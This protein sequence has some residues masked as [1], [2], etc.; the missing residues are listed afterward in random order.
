MHCLEDWAAVN[1]G[2]AF[3]NG[4]SEH[5]QLVIDYRPKT[6]RGSTILGTNTCMQV[7]TDVS[8]R[9][10]DRILYDRRA[11]NENCIWT[12]LLQYFQAFGAV[13]A[14]DVFN[15]VR[16]VKCLSFLPQQTLK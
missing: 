4:R 5:V 3:M 10:E 12:S 13:Y 11:V 6:A 16:C 7:D 15:S 14:A 1:A 9:V 8:C 2:R